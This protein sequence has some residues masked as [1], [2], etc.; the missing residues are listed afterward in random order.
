MNCQL[1]HGIRNNSSL[2][3]PELD[4]SFKVQKV[5]I[6]DVRGF[7][8]RRFFVIYLFFR[9][10]KNSNGTIYALYPDM[11]LVALLHKFFNKS[12]V[13]LYEI[14]D[15]QSQSPAFRILHNL[16]IY[17]SDYVFIT[18][19]KFS[20]EYLPVFSSTFIRKTLFISNAP[21]L[22]HYQ[23]LRKYHNKEP[24]PRNFTIGFVGNLRDYDHFQA[25]ENL[26]EKTEMSVLQAGASDFSQE[27]TKL[28]F[29]FP[30]RFIRIGRYHENDLSSIYGKFHV[31][32]CAYP[33]TYNYRH[34]VARRL[35]E[36][37]FLGIPLVISEHACG[38]ISHL[39]EN[40]IPFVTFTGDFYELE[41]AAR[42]L[43]QTICKM[44]ISY[45]ESYDKYNRKQYQ[46]INEINENK[47]LS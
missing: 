19:P 26:L 46:I 45:K 20:I 41:K 33:D 15:L 42:E 21:S 32:W 14:Q 5:G 44:N 8:F 31:M 34:H 30:K 37:C 17:F 29:R 23:N 40:H 12:T 36:A 24:L 10:L 11:L 7:D 1:I 38:N 4:H 2:S 18:S 13:V 9:T 25:I 39:E 28:Q 27:L 16:L 3:L 43:H 6:P 22:A 35:H 47:L